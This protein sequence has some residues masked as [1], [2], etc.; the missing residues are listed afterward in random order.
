M[1]YGEA[2]ESLFSTYIAKKEAV[3]G[4]EYR[5][6]K[7]PKIIKNI[8]EKLGLSPNPE[9]VIKITGSKGKGTTSKTLSHLLVTQGKRVGLVVSPEEIFHNDRIQINN[10][11]ISKELFAKTYFDLFPILEKQKKS[12]GELDYFSPVPFHLQN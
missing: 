6:Y 12:F 4:L 9:K 3:K 8:I 11:P 7:N 2:L 10:T 1:K 5:D